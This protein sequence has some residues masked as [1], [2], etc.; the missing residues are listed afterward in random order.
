VHIGHRGRS[1]GGLARDDHRV[2]CVV[3]AGLPMALL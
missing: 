2:A 1:D 3:R